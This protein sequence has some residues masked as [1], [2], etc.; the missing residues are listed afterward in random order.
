MSPLQVPGGPRISIKRKNLKRRGRPL[1]RIATKRKL[2]EKA[3]II[4]NDLIQRHGES[5]ETKN[6]D[7]LTVN[8]EEHALHIELLNKNAKE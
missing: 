6:I 2:N 5:E 1:E 3:T 8:L 4:Y 7:F